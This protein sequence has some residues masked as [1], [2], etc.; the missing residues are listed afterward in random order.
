MGCK[1]RRPMGR[2]PYRSMSGP[3]NSLKAHGRMMTA[4]RDAICP[5]PT[6]WLASHTGI[7]IA[8]RP[9]G[10]PWAKYMMEPVA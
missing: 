7:E 1:R 9:C 4:S 2:N 5:A 10:T 3:D 8:S 6:P